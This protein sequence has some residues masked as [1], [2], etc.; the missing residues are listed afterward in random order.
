MAGLCRPGPVL[1]LTTSALFKPHLN[2]APGYNWLFNLHVH[3]ATLANRIDL[4]E[5]ADKINFS[6]HAA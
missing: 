5:S 3:M 1:M 6:K 4:M 2:Q